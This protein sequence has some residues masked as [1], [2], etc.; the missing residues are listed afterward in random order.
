MESWTPGHT[1]EWALQNFRNLRTCGMH[2]GLCLLRTTQTATP[3][4]VR[5]VELGALVSTFVD[6]GQGNKLHHY[7][8]GK[9]GIIWAALQE[10]FSL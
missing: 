10:G 9:E 3:D 1:L 8:G 5:L 7:T 4:L 6:K 2:G